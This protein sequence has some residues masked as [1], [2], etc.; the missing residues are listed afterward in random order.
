[1]RQTFPWLGWVPFSLLGYRTVEPTIP[2]GI[3]CCPG[4][5]LR[6][7]IFLHLCW[8]QSPG[9][10]MLIKFQKHL[11]ISQGRYETKPICSIRGKEKHIG[12]S[13]VG[14]H[15]VLQSLQQLCLHL[16]ISL[17]TPTPLDLHPPLRG[18]PVHGE[19]QKNQGIPNIQDATPSQQFLT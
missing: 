4:N 5:F 9:T 14:V 1:M 17:P 8:A 3:A 15:E 12:Y 13:H 10:H 18:S 19:C 11:L 7:H 2:S 6:A 16:N